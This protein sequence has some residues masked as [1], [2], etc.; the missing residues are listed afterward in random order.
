MPPRSRPEQADAFV[1]SGWILGST[2]Q[3]VY[4]ATLVNP[5]IASVHYRYK[6][7]LLH[8]KIN[9]SIKETI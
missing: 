5:M 9:V 2:R 4:L 7:Y 8:G 6:V 3:L 1:S